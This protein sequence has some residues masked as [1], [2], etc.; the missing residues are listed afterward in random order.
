MNYKHLFPSR[1]IVCLLVLLVLGCG[2]IT[3]GFIIGPEGY[4]FPCPAIDTHFAPG[5]SEQKFQDIQVGMTKAEVL[6]RLGPPL[7][8]TTDPS[9]VYSRDGA[10][11]IWDFAWLVRVVNFDE[12]DIVKE[13]VAWVAYD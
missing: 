6:Q 4:F 3:V 11:G 12:N 2:L 5:Y 1:R 9:W 13:K 10:L 8:R 7:N